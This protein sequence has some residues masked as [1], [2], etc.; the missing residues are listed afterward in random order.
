[1]VSPQP[2]RLLLTDDEE[3]EVPDLAAE[4]AAKA[5]IT[6]DPRFEGEDAEDS[7]EKKA[8]VAKKPPVVK[9]TVAEYVDET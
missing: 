6:S 5:T 2:P 3:F 1:M 9:K 7:V 4:V 8:V